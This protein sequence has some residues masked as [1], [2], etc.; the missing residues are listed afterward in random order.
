MLP[1]DL[2]SIILGLLTFL[3][4]FGWFFD[5]RRHKAEVESLKAD[6][7]LKDLEL[8]QRFVRDYDEILVRRLR[9]DV[10][11]LKQRVYDL[12]TA[13]RAIQ[14]CPHWGDCPVLDELRKQSEGGKPSGGDPEPG[15]GGEE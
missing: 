2:T 12:E 1:I 7:R 9:S 6:N 10:E 13:I 15:D 3:N 11:S 4:G 8:A 14:D 5:R